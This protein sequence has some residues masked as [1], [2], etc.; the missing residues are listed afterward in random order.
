MEDKK[1]RE[2]KIIE[3]MSETEVKENF[4]FVH[5]QLGGG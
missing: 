3:I 4:S 5:Y 1:F 2:F